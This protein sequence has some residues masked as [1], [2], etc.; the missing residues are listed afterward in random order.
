[1]IIDISIYRGIIVCKN[2]DHVKFSHFRL[3][4]KER[5]FKRRH[6]M[7]RVSEVEHTGAVLMGLNTSHATSPFSIKNLKLFFLVFIFCVRKIYT[8]MRPFSL[9]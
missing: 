3:N 7:F 5:D 4:S 9:S 8:D 1:M 2:T 6:L